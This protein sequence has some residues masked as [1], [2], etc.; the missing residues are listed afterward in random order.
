MPGGLCVPMPEASALRICFLAGTLGR[1]GAE[2]QLIYMIRGL[3]REGAAVRLMS[4]TRGESFE[5]EIRALGV[6]VEWVGQSG[7]PPLRLGRVVRSLRRC[8]ADIIQSVHFYTNLYVAVAAR[9]TRS[10]GIGAIRGDLYDELGHNGKFGRW[11]LHLPQHLIANSQLAYDRA[12]EKGVSPAR[13]D[14]VE[15][16]VDG[17]ADEPPAPRQKPELRMLFVGRLCQPKRPDRFLRIAGRVVKESRPVRVRAVMAGDGPLRETV[18]ALAPA[19]GLGPDNFEWLGEQTDMSRVYRDGDFLVMS[20]DH[21]GT[22]NA[23]L[24]A[25]SYGLPVAATSVGGI[26]QVLAHGRGLLSRPEDEK[27]L[28]AAALRLASDAQLRTTLGQRGREYVRRQHAPERLGP[29]LVSVYR[30][31]LA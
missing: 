8:P 26:P 24:E 13:I 27:G 31:L 12:L 21:E 6:P 10:R 22:P 15:N 5:A 19:H 4:L 2:R 18:M 17:P 25:M 16:V 9:V 20:S 14:L 11:H 23:V 30:K 3:L 7:A 1:G 29:K 28:V